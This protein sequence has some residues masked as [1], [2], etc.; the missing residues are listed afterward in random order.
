MFDFINGT[1]NESGFIAQEVQEVIPS[2]VRTNSADGMLT[3]FVSSLVP[4]LVK[5][6]Q[7]MSS[8]FTTQK[9]ISPLAEV[10]EIKTNT[11]SPLSNDAVTVHLP[12]NTSFIV[13][14]NDNTP[15]ARISE[16]GKLTT[17]T[18]DTQEASV[19]GTLF[20]DRIVT[21]FGNLDDRIAT[22]ASSIPQI[23]TGSTTIVQNTIYEAPSLDESNV[24]PASTAALL[25]DMFKNQTIES[26]TIDL[27][28]RT[29]QADTLFLNQ[30]LSALGNTILG[31]TMITGSLMIDASL[32]F[33][34]TSIETVTEPL[35]LQKTRLANIDLMNGAMIID[36]AGNALFAGNVNIAGVLGVSTIKPLPMT[37]LI[38]DLA[39]D[40]TTSATPSAFGKL[41]VKG[42][43][44]NA[45]ATFNADGSA[46]VS[47]ALSANEIMASKF[48]VQTDKSATDSTKTASVGVGKIIHGTTTIIVSTDK[49]TEDSLI[50][51]T[52]TSAT[53]KTLSVITKK[54]GQFTV[55][56][57]SPTVNDISFN[58]WVIN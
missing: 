4:Y 24:L 6:M 37:D 16:E 34:N 1:K 31:E 18:I 46:S 53:D 3:F 2:L 14:D 56:I 10:T 35:F 32:Y 58:W 7:E 27:S 26:P 48:T 9:I 20:A 39:N 44:G 43:D 38:F 23:A 42:K 8:Q 29:I 36:T 12:T 15:V 28:G 13:T 33:S 41:I 57:T 25:A 55:A 19:A 11:I 40:A 49:V 5:A 50:F 45:V 51:I 22:L 47:G 21:K 30:N 52:P 54:E 17:K